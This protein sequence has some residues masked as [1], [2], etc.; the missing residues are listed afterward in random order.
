MSADIGL[1]GLS[2][3]GSNLVLNMNDHGFT[4]C[5]FNRTVSKVDEFLANEA[6]GTKVIGAQSIDRRDVSP[7]HS[8][9][10]G[11]N[12]PGLEL[13]N[14]PADLTRCQQ[15]GSKRPRSIRADR[16]QRAKRGADLP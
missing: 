9:G 14:D 5:A 15:A 1:I 10:G 8:S 16:R 11:L 6:K 7:R 4:V 2:V 12:E 3:M 13:A